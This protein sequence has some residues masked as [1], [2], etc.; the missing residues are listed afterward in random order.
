MGGGGRGGGLLSKCP[1]FAAGALDPRVQLRRDLLLAVRKGPFA[2]AR[3]VLQ[4]GEVQGCVIDPSA[5]ALP[6]PSDRKP[7]KGLIRQS[8]HP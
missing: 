1:S 2:W 4:R 3:R 6:N 8:E 7:V 5:W